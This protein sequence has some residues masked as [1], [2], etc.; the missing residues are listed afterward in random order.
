[1]HVLGRRS[2]V[3]HGPPPHVV[4]PDRRGPALRAAASGR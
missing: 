2:P 4:A 3:Q 1:M